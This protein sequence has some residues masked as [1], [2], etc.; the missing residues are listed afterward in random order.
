[1]NLSFQEL[2]I[3]QERAEL[4]ANM[5]FSE[6]TNIQ[7]QAIPQLLNGRDV[8]GQSQTGT[9]KTAAFSLPILERL[10]PSLKAVQA[11][12]LTPTRELAIQV[13][14]AALSPFL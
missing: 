4:L 5:G 12:V 8:V 6:P 11:I 14:A 13:H 9:G 1:M 7:T 3:S 10:D 2:G